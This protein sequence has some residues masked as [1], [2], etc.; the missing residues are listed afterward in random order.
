MCNPLFEWIRKIDEVATNCLS[1]PG[2]QSI[3]GLVADLDKQVIRDEGFMNFLWDEYGYVYGNLYVQLGSSQPPRPWHRLP[4]DERRVPHI[5][6]PWYTKSNGKPRLL[7]EEKRQKLEGEIAAQNVTSSERLVRWLRAHETD[8]HTEVIVPW[9][10]IIF[11]RLYC[12]GPPFQPNGEHIGALE[13]WLKAEN[14]SR[15]V[16]SEL[17]PKNIKQFLNQVENGF[18]PS[19]EDREA[20]A[21]LARVNPVLEIDMLDSRTLL[22]FR[23]GRYY[24]PLNQ[25]PWGDIFCLV[26][27]HTNKE[28]QP[29]EVTQIKVLFR[30]LAHLG[31]EYP[32]QMIATERT[33][34]DQW[35]FL[36]WHVSHQL[37]RP[38]AYLRRYIEKM[39]S[40]PDERVKEICELE[41]RVVYIEELVNYYRLKPKEVIEGVEVLRGEK[42]KE[43]VEKSIDWV[44][45]YAR[46]SDY[47]GFKVADAERALL[48][49]PV[50]MEEAASKVEV[51][52]HT[53]LF[54]DDY[55]RED[56]LNAFRYFNYPAPEMQPLP[57]V[58]LIK[59]SESGLE[60]ILANPARHDT[61]DSALYENNGAEALRTSGPLSLARFR[62]WYFRQNFSSYFLREVAESRERLPDHNE[63]SRWHPNLGDL[64]KY[65]ACSPIEFYWVKYTLKK[66]SK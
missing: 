4:E 6:L 42:I 41:R 47:A 14:V 13:K 9:G 46:E 25:P 59:T 60:L 32:R 33:A 1:S 61:L 26:A 56:I 31:I 66:P 64:R 3:P 43:E 18:Q 5:A 21:N 63:V 7:E 36:N 54:R 20:A 40:S 38:V 19:C 58:C 29:G 45:Q 37:Q 62:H 11:F 2:E 27:F 57:F 8:G 24:A 53:A 30:R 52:W 48:N 12:D 39:K 10:E 50:L 16:A 35:G 51:Y 22:L 49:P 28:L 44:I 34:E 23:A 55:L 65:P 15:P 17:F